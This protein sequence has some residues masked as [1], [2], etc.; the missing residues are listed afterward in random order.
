VTRD[1]PAV[2]LGAILRRADRR[3]AIAPEH[4]YRLLTLRLWGRGVVLRQEVMGED[5]RSSTLIRV[6]AGQL[7]L[8]KIDARNGAVGLVPDDLDGAVVTNDFP[9]Y[10]VDA[11]RAL[12]RF[13]E[14]LTK[15]SQFTDG[16][17]AASEGTT[18]R[19]RL[20]EHRFLQLEIPLPPLAEQ[21]RIAAKLDALSARTEEAKLL[22]QRSAQHVEVL[23]RAIAGS[24]FGRLSRCPAVPLEELCCEVIDCPHSNPIYSEDGI[25]VLRSPDV[26]WGRLL[27]HQARKT[28]EAEYQRRTHR[29]EPR[30]GDMVLV[31]E[32]GGTGKAGLVQPGQRFSLGQRLMLLRPD[33]RLVLPQFLLHQWLS[34]QIYEDQIAAHTKGSASPHLNVGAVTRLRFILPSLDEQRRIVAYLDGLQAKVDELKQLQARTAADLD[35]L[36]PSILDKTFR[37]EL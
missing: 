12:P 16:C 9:A 35:A 19:V 30:P 14:W 17:R 37:G 7:V 20:K 29:G 8:S 6:R 23:S 5:I 24:V 11:T 25:P 26:G 13:L 18:N 10:D 3:I 4:M 32:G 33:P 28:S 34:P 31:R 1:W 36:M 27:P 15:T 22:R 2:P 21:R